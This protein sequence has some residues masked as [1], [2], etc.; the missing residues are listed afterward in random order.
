MVNVN[1]KAADIGFQMTDSSKASGTSVKNA[2]SEQFKKLLQGKQDEIQESGTQEVSKDTKPEKT[3]APEKSEDSQGKDARE[4]TTEE[5][6]STDDSQAR[7]LLAAYQMDQGFRPEVLTVEPEVVIEMTEG[8][9]AVPE[10]ADLTGTM[11]SD[12]MTEQ[13]AVQTETAGFQ[14]EVRSQ[15]TVQV[16]E[17]EVQTAAVERLRHLSVKRQ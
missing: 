9:E 11:I 2:Q 4:D 6:V 12:A 8:V 5:T 13:P 10:A 7:G 1:V 16:K 14:A 3:E 15:E 17:P